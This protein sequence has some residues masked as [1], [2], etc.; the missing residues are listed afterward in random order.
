M[1]LGKWKKIENEEIYQCGK[2]YRIR[3]DKIMTPGGKEGTYFVI[4]GESG[5]VIIIPRDKDN[6]FHLTKQHRYPVEN[7]SIE[8]P[9]G[10]TDAGESDLDAAKRELRE[11]MNLVSNNWERVG[12]FYIAEGISSIKFNVYLASDVYNAEGESKDPIDKNLHESIK[13]SLE[14]IKDMIRKGEINAGPTISA[15]TLY[16]LLQN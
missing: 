13:V 9:A 8:F 10:S 5:S 7:F 12:E 4:D 11:E 15:V 3:K 1:S 6:N 16:G 14:D 2:F